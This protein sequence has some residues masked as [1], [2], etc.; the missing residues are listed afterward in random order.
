[1]VLG[2]AA[3]WLVLRRP[4][5]QLEPTAPPPPQI[6]AAEGQAGSSELEAARKRIDELEA[7]NLK[8]ADRVQSLLRQT[9]PHT[10]AGS[11][12]SATPE[13]SEDGEGEG[14]LLSMFTGGSEKDPSRRAAMKEMMAT[15]IRQQVD[16]KLARMQERLSLTPEQAQK[17]REILE[18]QYSLGLELA[19]KSMTGKASGTDVKQLQEQL[20]NPEEQLKSL[21]TPEQQAGYTELQREERRTTARLV[22]NSELIQMQGSLGLTE[23]QQDQAFQIL[24]EQAEHQFEGETGSTPTLDF[25]SAYTRKLEALKQVLTPEQHERYAQLQEQQLKLI[26]SM[27]PKDGSAGDV[28]VPQIQVL[29]AP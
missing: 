22:A 19:E 24:A 8:L 16:G 6:A 20:G 10:A 1:M 25:R 4:S 14:N 11:K 29:P 27:M 12:T 9:A 26:E 3:T 23:A 17:A 18:S 5:S 13:S 21:L 15:A 7:T 28:A 2:V